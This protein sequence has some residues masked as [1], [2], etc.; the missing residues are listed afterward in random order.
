MEREIARFNERIMVQENAVEIDKY[1]NHL[2]SWKD[3]YECF[4]YASTYQNDKERAS[5]VTTEEQTINFEVR[6]CPELESLSSTKYR[7]VFH[8]SIYDIVSVDFMNY[9]RKNIRIVCKLEK[10]GGAS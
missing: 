9:Q 2:A 10:K 4:T 6:W 8:G 7:I 1:G 3:Y 5:A